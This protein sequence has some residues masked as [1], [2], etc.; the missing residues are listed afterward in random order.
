VSYA[1][2]AQDLATT[3]GALRVAVHRL[4]EH[5]RDRLRAEVAQT[6]SNPSEVDAEL[7]YLIGVISGGT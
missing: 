6:V 1:A 3:E 2:L 7:H 4:R 5:Y